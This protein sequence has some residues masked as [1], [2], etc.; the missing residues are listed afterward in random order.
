MRPAKLTRL[1]NRAMNAKTKTMRAYWKRS[2]ERN[3]H[4]YVTETVS[5]DGA[6]TM[7]GLEILLTHARRAGWDGTLQ[8]SDRREGV[9]ERFGKQSQA[10]LYRGWI[11]GRA[12]FN[13][14][15]P[16]G[17]SSHELRSDGNRLFRKSAGLP[18]EWWQLGMDVGSPASLV[19]ELGR[20]GVKARQPYSSPSEAHHVNLT[21]D[22]MSALINMKE[23]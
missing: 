13:P 4:K 14:A 1:R 5:F 10:A 3:R 19:H 17:R 9:A 8:S 21:E 7:R 12:G 22:P 20:V 16:P 15:N 18:L 2:L 23:I 11:Q 6:P